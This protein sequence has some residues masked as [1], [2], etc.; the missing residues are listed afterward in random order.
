M[1]HVFTGWRKVGKYRI[2]RNFLP[3]GGIKISVPDT[4]EFAY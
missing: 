1:S 2:E 3:E 4:A